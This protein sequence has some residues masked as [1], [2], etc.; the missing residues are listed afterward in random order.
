[1]FCK[2]EFKL[3]FEF[4]LR[5]YYDLSKSEVWAQ[6]ELNEYKLTAFKILWQT[7]FQKTNIEGIDNREQ[8]E[9]F[10]QLLSIG[11]GQLDAKIIYTIEQGIAQDIFFIQLNMLIIETVNELVSDIEELLKP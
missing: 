10:C 3:K 1:M 4:F 5:C 2:E 7:R 6:V 9:S 8:F 11:I